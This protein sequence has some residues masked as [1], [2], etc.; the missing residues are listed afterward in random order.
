M[1]NPLLGSQQRTALSG[2]FEDISGY[3]G[4]RDWETFYSVF[5][6]TRAHA[7][8]AEIEDELTQ[9]ARATHWTPIVVCGSGERR[10]RGTAARRGALDPD[11]DQGRS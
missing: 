10:R 8:I 3:A 9:R 2:V 5:Y 6:M 4:S 11:A 7:R 1:S